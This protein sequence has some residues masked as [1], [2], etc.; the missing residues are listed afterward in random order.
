VSWIDWTVFLG[1]LAYVVID[2]V[3][4]GRGTKTLEG[5]FVGGRTITW[6]AA[7]LSIMAT[8][9]SAITVIGT[10]GQGFESGMEFVQIY[11]G[12]AFAMVLLS[13]FF[14]PMY[15]AQPILTAYEFLE[16]RFGPL[17][18]LL[19]SLIFLVSRCLAFGVVLYAP[20][21][22]L[23][24]LLG[25]D[26]VA[27]VIFI[28]VLTTLYTMF[29]GV[30]AVIAT[31]VKQMVVII[32]GLGLVLVLLLIRVI[33]ELG[34]VGGLEVLGVTG[35]LNAV[36]FEAASWDFVPK[37]VGEAGQSFWND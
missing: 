19:A 35:K 8:Q 10:T 30:K 27:T 36:E 26:V 24:A 12:L 13:I 28:G 18:R 16:R 14:V 22:V 3:R 9:A 33:P 4:R 2:G 29:G 15:R 31:D 5:Y 21:V 1:F 17:T 11:F 32:G 37:G 20:G 7:G 25:F 23:S 34:F 6:W